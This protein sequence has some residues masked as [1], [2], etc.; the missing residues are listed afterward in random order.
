MWESRRGQ[1]P[2]GCLTMTRPPRPG[3]RGQSK[4]GGPGWRNESG[5]GDDMDGFKNA[6]R[7]QSRGSAGHSVMSG[8]L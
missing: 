8:R 7:G 2:G 4:V 5:P 6:P 3:C 1:R